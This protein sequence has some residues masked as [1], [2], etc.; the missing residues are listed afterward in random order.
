[1]RKFHGFKRGRICRTSFMTPIS[2][3]NHMF[4]R[5]IWD[6]L[7]ECIFENFVLT[8]IPFN[9]GQLQNSGQ[10]QKFQSFVWL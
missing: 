9:R 2:T 4:G 6:K 5:A 3:S 7:T 8:L 10:L 1:M